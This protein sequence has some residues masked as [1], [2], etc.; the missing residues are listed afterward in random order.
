MKR[1]ITI[2]FTFLLL[3]SFSQTEELIIENYLNSEL[4]QTHSLM[5]YDFEKNIREGK[6]EKIKEDF[7]NDETWKKN[8]ENFLINLEN[9]KNYF[10]LCNIRDTNLMIGK[11]Y[12]N[13]I[14]TFK[15]DFIFYYDCLKEDKEIQ[16][17]ITLTFLW[18]NNNT[19]GFDVTFREEEKLTNELEEL[20]LELEKEE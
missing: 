13:E 10:P 5:A 15:S 12:Q 14:E 1:I 6:I 3:N 4:Y 8:N 19:I 17:I 20:L 11:N 16:Y 2:I 18:I 7:P 9:S